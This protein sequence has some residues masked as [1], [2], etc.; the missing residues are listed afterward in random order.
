MLTEEFEQR[1]ELEQAQKALEELLLE[2]RQRRVGLEEEKAQQEE[3]IAQERQRLQSVENSRLS[4][5]AKLQVRT[6]SCWCFTL[7]SQFQMTKCLSKQILDPKCMAL[8]RVY[9]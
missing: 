6:G 4:M 1:Q 9:S 7:V 5:D 8:N 3:L 2:E